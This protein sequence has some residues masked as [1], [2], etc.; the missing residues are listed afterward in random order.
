MSI[1]V[2]ANSATPTSGSVMGNN[3]VTITGSG[4]S[5]LTTIPV[6]FGTTGSPK[7]TIISD[8]TL[9]AVS[10]NTGSTGAVT[11][12]VVGGAGT[13]HPAGTFT[14]KGPQIMTVNPAS[15]TT[16]GNQEITLGGT[17][18]KGVDAINF[19]K[20]GAIQTNI[21]IISDSEIKVV[22]PPVSAAGVVNVVAIDGQ[23]VQSPAT[24]ANQF[25]YVDVPNNGVPFVFD[26]EDASTTYIQFLGDDSLDG[27]YY[28]SSGTKQTLAPHTGYLLSDLSSSTPVL[29]GAPTDVPAVLV[30]AF[31]GRVYVSKGAAIPGMKAG[32]TPNANDD[33][34]DSVYQYFE[35]TV[36]KSQLNVDL[37]YIDFTAFS[38]SLSAES[39]PHGTNKLQTT[40]PTNELVSTA[41][42]SAKSTAAALSYSDGKTSTFLRVISPQLGNSGLYHDFTNYLKTTL[43]KKTVRIAGTYV[44]TV[45]NNVKQPTGN[46]LT[47]AQSYDYT[48]KFDDKGNIT[49]AP[50]AGSGNGY[51]AGVPKVQQG[52]GVE[53]AGGNIVISFDDFNNKIGIYGCNTPYTLGSNAKTAGITNDIYGQVVGDLLA[54]LNFGYVGSTVKFENKEIG[55]LTSTEWWGGTMADG[56]VVSSDATPGG[57][58]IYF[59]GAQSNAENYNSYSGSLAPLTAGYGFPLQDR[60]GKNLM[61]LNTSIDNNAYLK[62]WIDKQAIAPA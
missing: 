17:N 59:S 31:S 40:V 9:T 36:D 13:Q 27:Y 32:W 43:K 20:T 38:L 33:T 4:F 26:A 44:G 16:A 12:Y 5:T 8:T 2:N 34:V 57:K 3:L 60:L 1:T 48:G 42:G 39:A 15:T 41:E 52:P 19:G 30:K 49:L 58:G 53:T 56:T 29:T 51:A 7:V 62:V 45:I 54:G 10:P 14:Y 28:D 11:I 6:L 35:P 61:T 47:Q 50:N 22:N 46:P 18:L 37:S 55:T 23:G 21:T 24:T 25:K